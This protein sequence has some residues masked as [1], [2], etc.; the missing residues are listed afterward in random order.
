MSS[1][2]CWLKKICYEQNRLTFISFL[3]LSGRSQMAGRR[4]DLPA[5]T[6]WTLGAFLSTS[7]SSSSHLVHRYY[8]YSRRVMM[9]ATMRRSLA[10]TT[11]TITTGC[12]R[13]LRQ[14]RTL[15]T[16]A[17][18]P[19]SSSSSQPCLSPE[20]QNQLHEALRAAQAS[21]ALLDGFEKGISSCNS[22]STTPELQV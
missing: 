5:K 17:P 19:S 13:P 18:P 20:E 10:A 9:I 4:K 16:T 21:E 22:Q 11:T 8:Y 6:R 3:W 1:R 2:F 15:S 7:L 14:G 12:I